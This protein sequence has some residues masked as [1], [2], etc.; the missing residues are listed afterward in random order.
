MLSRRQVCHQYIALNPDVHAL[1]FAL[2]YA[3]FYT[4]VQKQ[5]GRIAAKRKF[6]YYAAEILGSMPRSR[7]LKTSAERRISEF[8]RLFRTGMGGTLPFLSNFFKHNT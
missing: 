3:T 2:L 5:T 8:E 7:L 4:F 6:D 1:F